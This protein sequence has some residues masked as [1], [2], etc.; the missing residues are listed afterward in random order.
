MHAKRAAGA[1]D[2]HPETL[3]ALLIRL[4]P[5]GISGWLLLDLTSGPEKE[6]PFNS[7]DHR[8]APHKEGPWR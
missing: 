4:T 6:S 5:A 2:R 7:L 3:P 1:N 8:I